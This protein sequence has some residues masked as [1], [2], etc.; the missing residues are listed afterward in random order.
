MADTI[1]KD[2]PGTL[3][4]VAAPSGAG[5]T[6][7]VQALVKQDAQIQL[8]VSC[9]TRPQRTG[10]ID[11]QHYYFI[12]QEAFERKVSQ[13]AFLEYAEVF[14]Y[15]YG[16]ERAWVEA[17]LAQGKD[18]ILEIDWQGARQV[19]AL[20]PDSCGIYVLPPGPERLRQRLEAR[21]RDDQAVIDFRM[22]KMAE[23]VSHC[24]E[25]DY[26]VV[27][28][29]FDKTLAEMYSIIQASRLRAARQLH[30]QH[31]LIERLLSEKNLQP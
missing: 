27:N 24:H 7:L 29:T 25:F 4:I 11:G 9:T 19:K 17:Q 22:Q 18:I 12:E 2:L 5:K 3:F 8:S 6:S 30:C 23:Q 20:R 1:P 21:A 31:Q 14:G 13:Q 26:I 16:T 10:E 28:D 15:G